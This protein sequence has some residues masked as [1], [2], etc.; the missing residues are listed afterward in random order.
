VGAAP[1]RNHRTLGGPLHAFTTGKGQCSRGDTPTTSNF[2]ITIWVHSAAPSW[3]PAAIFIRRITITLW[4][5]N[6]NC[7]ASNHDYKNII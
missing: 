4:T 3:P 1:D 6:P 2:S 5:S 7:A